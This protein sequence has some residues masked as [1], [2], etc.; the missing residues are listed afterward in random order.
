MKGKA[1]VKLVVEVEESAMKIIL[2]DVIGQSVGE[3]E[4]YRDDRDMT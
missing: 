4:M 3:V 1:F 2:Y